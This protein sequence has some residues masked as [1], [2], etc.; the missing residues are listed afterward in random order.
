MSYWKILKEGQVFN[1]FQSVYA[2]LYLCY[3]PSFAI[4]WETHFSF[5]N[6]WQER[7]QEKVSQLCFFQDGLFPFLLCCEVKFRYVTI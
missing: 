4:K 5:S 2:S 7:V 1:I 3:K 6:T